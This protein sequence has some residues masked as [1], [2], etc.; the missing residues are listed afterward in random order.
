M[1]ERDWGKIRGFLGLCHRAGQVILGQDA[2]VDAIRKE[3]AALVLLDES[4][5]QTSTKRF[6]NACHSHGVPLYGVPE[7]LIAGAL[8]RS[9]AMA[10]AVRRGTMAG[11]LK[12]LLPNDAVIQNQQ[13]NY[14]NDRADI[15]G[16]Q[17]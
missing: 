8:G 3:S 1:T 16:V 4:S 11:K 10:A 15:A 7:G 17:A 13:L 2:C 14:P 12:E 5:T 9:G 6:R